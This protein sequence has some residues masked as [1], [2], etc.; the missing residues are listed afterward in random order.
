MRSTQIE[1]RSSL[2]FVIV[3]SSNS[4][5]TGSTSG[6]AK[7]SCSRRAAVFFLLEESIDIVKGE[8]KF[9]VR[10]VAG[11]KKVEAIRVLKCLMQRIEEKEQ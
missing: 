3:K 4:S 2:A 7:L 9:L 1:I 11:D 10:F 6:N 8:L 5:P